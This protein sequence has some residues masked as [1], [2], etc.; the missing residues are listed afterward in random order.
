M[1]HPLRGTEKPGRRRRRAG[2]L[3]LAPEGI[4]ARPLAL[5]LTVL[6]TRDAHPTQECQPTEIVEGAHAQAGVFLAAHVQ[7]LVPPILNP[8]F[9][10]P[11]L[12]HADQTNEFLAGVGDGDRVVVEGSPD[13]HLPASSINALTFFRERETFLRVSH[14]LAL[15]I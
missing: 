8:P 6:P 5:R 1:V 10:A 15:A 12:G 3:M 14:P 4:T 7:E 2:L 9:V 13:R 11:R